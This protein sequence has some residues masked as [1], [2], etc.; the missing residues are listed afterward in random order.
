[1]LFDNSADSF[2]RNLFFTGKG[3]V[4]KTSLSCALAVALADHGKRVLLVS[5]DPAS[6]L[7]DVLGTTISHQP[8]MVVQCENLAAVNIDPEDAARQYR[9]RVVGPFRGVLPEESLASIEEQLSGACTME[10]AAFDEF[11]RL[12][13]DQEI[14]ARY[15]HIVFDTAPTGH[16]L[17]LLQLPSAWANFLDE[18]TSGVSCLGPLSG[19]KEQE[20]RYKSAVAT[21]A[22]EK[23]TTMYLV[24]RPDSPSLNEAARTHGE[25]IKLGIINQQLLVNGVF[26]SH[27]SDP[28]ALA[29]RKR[30]QTALANI[31]P[32]IGEIPRQEFTLRSW[33]PLGIARLRIF[34]APE[35]DTTPNRGLTAS[36]ATATL[37]PL[38]DV[39]L[40]QL[41]VK[42]SGLLMTM[43]KG[44][45]G[46][47][48]VASYLAVELARQGHRVHLATT[49]PA[50]HLDFS[51]A[52]RVRGLTI[53]R[54][55]PEIETK[56]YRQAVMARTGA[57]LDEEGRKLL[58]EGLRSPCTEEI[59]VFQAFAQLLEKATEGFLVIDTAPTG[60]TLLLLDAAQSYHREVARNLGQAPVEISKLLP[61]LRDPDYSKI[62][63]V[64]LPETTPVNEAA[65][66]QADLKRAG[67]TPAGWIINQCLSPL[68]V[69]DPLLAARQTGEYQFIEK[70][71]NELAPAVFILP[72]REDL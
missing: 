59:A 24:V 47:T 62:F 37:P 57:G 46:K 68:A 16:T 33:M 15:D 64:T 51:L 35:A 28:L 30:Q 4:G 55:D 65:S 21:L 44:G 36:S 52:D 54:V 48:T 41:G 27:S 29:L 22:D 9:E 5:T 67:I 72:W 34:A 50:A 18:N 11:V 69:S 31:P 26:P 70:V 14:A 71:R 3:G 61:R 66:L 58:A 49:D 19:L 43:G 2:T 1:M 32:A 63:I 45:V 7:D 20:A 23:Q 6:N 13:G 40:T 42:N 39:L 8:T 17:R 56:K 25:L 60:H 10:I 38:L 12:L 53:S